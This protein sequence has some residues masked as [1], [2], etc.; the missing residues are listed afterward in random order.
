MYFCDKITFF[1]DDNVALMSEVMEVD[2]RN[3]DENII[4]STTSGTATITTMMT[5]VIHELA[6][7]DEETRDEQGGSDEDWNEDT[8]MTTTI[9][10]EST[11]NGASEGRTF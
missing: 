5:E 8:L 9:S 2:G 3:M 7:N 1:F 4:S 10:L 11:N 6:N